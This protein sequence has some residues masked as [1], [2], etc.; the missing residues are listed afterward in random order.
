MKALLLAAVLAP[1]LACAGARAAGT[2]VST[3]PARSPAL[4]GRLV[5]RP[6]AGTTVQ[7]KTKDGWT[8]AGT[9]WPATT[10][11]TFLLV[12]M[13]GGR[14]GDW[15][16]LARALPALGHGYLALDLRG[17][18]DSIYDP[19]GSTTT[20]RKFRKEGQDNEFNQMG[21]DLEAA[22]LYLSSAG[23]SESSMVVCG[24]A[25]GANVAL[26]WVVQRSSVPAVVLISPGINYRDV[27]SMAAMRSLGPRAVLIVSSLSDRKGLLEGQ[28]LYNV[29]RQF[30]GPAYAE[31]ESEKK[32]YGTKLLTPELVNRILEWTQRPVKLELLAVSTP[33]VTAG[34]VPSSASVSTA[35]PAVLL[36]APTRQAEGEGPPPLLPL[37]Q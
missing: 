15:E 13:L 23:V 14:R 33:T 26:K 27:L 18:G 8:L 19:Q 5:R 25:L 4:E 24:A 2:D 30:S 11:R 32:G 36:P 37:A 31:F 6:L 22:A 21:E 17:H 9:F 10:G 28:I 1:V 20:W 34:V 7:F 3:A 35:A 12:P 16:P 29:A